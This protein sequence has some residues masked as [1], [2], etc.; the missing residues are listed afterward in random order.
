MYGNKW[1]LCH[2]GHVSSRLRMFCFPYAGSGSSVFN[3]WPKSI[4]PGI[5]L[6][7][8][9]LPGRES[10]YNEK[11]Y[12]RID[13]LVKKLANEMR[14]LLNKPFIFFGHSIG[15]HISF[16]LARFLRRN[17]MHVPKHLIVSGARA[18]QIESRNPDPLHYTMEDSEFIKEL[19]ELKGMPDDLLKNQELLDLVIPILKADIEM[20]NTMEYK[21]ENPLD[22]SISSFGGLFD[23]RVKKED[24]E[25]WKEQTCRDFSLAMLPGGHFFM[26]THRDQLIRE[27]NSHINNNMNFILQ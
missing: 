3:E 15:A 23:E 1:I 8:V 10:R 2:N 14:P 24:S 25:A 13:D 17:N 20:I 21:E 27:I 18:P 19:I 16:H 11:P 22:C 6:C 26:N 5:E 4:L 9:K 12:R 7:V